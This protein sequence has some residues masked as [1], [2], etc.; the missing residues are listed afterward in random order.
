MQVSPIAVCKAQSIKDES[1][2]REPI[3]FA[4]HYFDRFYE[5]KNYIVLQVPQLK[6][7]SLLPDV[8]AAFLYNL[9]S[10]LPSPQ[11]RISMQ[12]P[13]NNN[14]FRFTTTNESEAIQRGPQGENVTLL[15]TNWDMGI[16]LWSRN[17][18]P[19]QKIN[20]IETKFRITSENESR[21]NDIR[22][23]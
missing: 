22:L 8:Q 12:L 3:Q 14:T 7:A 16:P 10:D 4:L 11:V 2:L 21:S 13:Y 23:K 17:I 5:D 18:L 1:L 20:Y 19:E 6:A 9:G 15:G